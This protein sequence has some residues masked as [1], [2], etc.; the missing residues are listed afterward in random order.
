MLDAA[1]AGAR[2]RLVNEYWSLFTIHA[3]SISGSQRMAD[4]SAVNH[5]RYFERVM[6]RPQRPSDALWRRVYWASRWAGDPTGAWQ[7]LSDRLFGP[8]Q[9]SEL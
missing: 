4:E 7:R 6:G 3:G 2:V 1:L 5:R 8:P 9:L